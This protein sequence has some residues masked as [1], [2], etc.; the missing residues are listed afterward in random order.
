MTRKP[1]LT[2]REMERKLNETWSKN[3]HEKARKYELVGVRY[4]NIKNT[5]EDREYE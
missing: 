5:Q 2:I 3:H 1:G 4:S